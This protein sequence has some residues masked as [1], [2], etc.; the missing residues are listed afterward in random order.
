MKEVEIGVITHYFG[1]LSVGIIK[2]SKPLT[3]GDKIHVKGAHDDFSQ[4]VDSMQIE[5]E[6]VDEAKS[7]QQVG[8]KVLG[9]VHENDKVFKVMPD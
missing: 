1:K 5:H 9:K 2:L 8:I 6:K 3:V 4:T 7:G